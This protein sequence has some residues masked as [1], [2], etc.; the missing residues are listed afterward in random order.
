MENKDTQSSQ[1]PP[2]L[3]QLSSNVQSQ[4]PQQRQS[5]TNQP[6]LPSNASSVQ[7]DNISQPS[8]SA[9][10]PPPPPANAQLEYE[11]STIDTLSNQYLMPQPPAPA[12]TRAA[13]N[14][15]QPPHIGTP[16]PPP[17]QLNLST[18]TP[19]VPSSSSSVPPPSLQQYQPFSTTNI[20]EDLSRSNA[21]LEL[22]HSH[23]YPVTRPFYQSMQPPTSQQLQQQQTSDADAQAGSS[24]LNMMTSPSSLHAQQ[25]PQQQQH[26]GFYP[27]QPII[28]S[29]STTAVSSLPSSANTSTLTITATA[30]AAPGAPPMSFSVPT[31]IDVNQYPDMTTLVNSNAHIV[32]PLVEHRFVDNKVCTI[33]GKKITRDMSRHMR[34][35]QTE[36]RFNCKFPKNQCRHKLGKFNRPYDFKKHLLNRHFKFDDPSIKRL[37]NLSDKLNHWG[38]C[39]CGLRF[40]GKDWLDDHILTDDPTRKCPFIE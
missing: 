11:Y 2:Q 13:T 29:S 31:H 19:Q 25:P 10:P 36:L 1:S 32:V 40:L 35:H 22:R 30:G 24:S 34:T 16:P 4:Q 21:G 8:T 39:P 20:H 9:P 12:H 6:P 14:F 27:P 37:H 17:A 23:S 26:H 33:C 38:T 3:Y 18:S 28:S 7:L 5:Q 15:G